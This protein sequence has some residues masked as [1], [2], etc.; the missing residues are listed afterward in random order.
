LRKG[1]FLIQKQETVMS[2]KR[3]SKPL[4]S[5]AIL[6]LALVGWA[7]CAAIMGIG[8]SITS[9][10]N[11]LVIHAI[12]APIIFLLISV[13][14]FRKFNYTTPLITAASFTALVMAMDFFVVG[15]VIQRSL[16]MFTSILGTWLPFALIFFSS[17]ITGLYA[18]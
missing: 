13:L 1:A 5:G 14:Y 7:L 18:A 6:G 4:K 11:T 3:M 8:M 15:L 16:G 12:G 17:Y 2:A 9:L 10:W